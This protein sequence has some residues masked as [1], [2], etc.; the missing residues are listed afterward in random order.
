MQRAV[1]I[2]LAS[3]LAAC[4]SPR[5]GDRRDASVLGDAERPLVEQCTSGAPG[6]SG[7]DDDLDGT[8]DEGCEW[9]FG[10]PSALTTMHTTSSPLTSPT[11]T[12]DKR[13]LYTVD[14]AQ[15]ALVVASRPSRDLPFGAPTLAAR[16]E[17]SPITAA[18]IAGDELEVVV[19]VPMASLAHATRAS[20][21]APFGALETITLNVP[22]PHYHPHLS[23]D[24]TEL[25]FVAQVDSIFR[26]FR[27]T[28]P[29]RGEPFAPAVPAL[30]GTLGNE[31]TPA[32]S[33]DGRTL[34][35]SINGDLW[36]FE[37]ASRDAAL[38]IRGSVGLVPAGSSGVYPFASMT[39][40]ELFFVGATR[41]WSPVPSAT[42]FRAPIC[43]DGPCPD[44]S[45]PC[46]GGTRSDDGQHC[47]V[48]IR[49]PLAWDEARADCEARGAHL[50]T[51]SSAE[52]HGL[53]ASLNAGTAQWLGATDRQS[54]CNL[55]DAPGCTFDWIGDDDP[56]VYAAW[57]D[58]EPSGTDPATMAREDCLAIGTAGAFED[59]DCALALPYACESERYL[60]W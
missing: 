42:I 35:A 46:E 57:A 28:R 12:G 30:D 31:L 9:F 48:P 11:L 14:L 26:V 23:R 25:F 20:T 43:R 1:L 51:L 24:G 41:P 15:S 2:A 21:D 39:T 52:E 54:E 56:F 8:I 32:L 45:I 36:R 33:E 6:T 50:A 34:F 53:V 40:R 19:E 27:A 22:P 13:R 3:A 10:A 29:A 49:V 5:D 58:L 38:E 18:T 47:Y 55:V 7:F 16:W 17:G 60:A 44:R 37:R 59:H 4:N